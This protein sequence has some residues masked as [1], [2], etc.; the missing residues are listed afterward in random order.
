M[1]KL[2]V[3]LLLIFAASISFSQA[4]SDF[5]GVWKSTVK[6]GNKP[7]FPTYILLNADGTFTGGVDS[8][9]NV[10]DPNAWK[11]KWDVTSDSEIKLI[12]DDMGNSRIYV[13]VSGSKYI[14]KFDE[15]NGVRTKIQM[16]EQDWYLEK[17]N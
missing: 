12:V 15:Q 17:V 4:K 14:Y 1:K 6:A 3:V 11:G 2:F 7:V 16:L 10:I 5:A 8:I 13:N 9:G